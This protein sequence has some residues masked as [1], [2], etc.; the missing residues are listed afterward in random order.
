MGLDE[1]VEVFWVGNTLGSEQEA[2]PSTPF[3]EHLLHMLDPL[4]VIV[5]MKTTKRG[6]LVLTSWGPERPLDMFRVTQH[7]RGRGKTELSKS[8][9][10]PPLLG[11]TPEDG[12]RQWWGHGSSLWVFSCVRT[13]D[14]PSH[15]HSSARVEVGHAFD[16]C[17]LCFCPSLKLET[18]K[19]YTPSQA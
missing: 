17:F 8:Q 7:I 13:P 4:L 15:P 19:V 5:C 16:F 11:M 18:V 1:W 14:H 9:P 12:A 2:V 6:I 10:F 3:M